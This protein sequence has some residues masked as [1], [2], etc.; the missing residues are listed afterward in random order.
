MSARHLLVFG[1]GYCGTEVARRAAVAGWTVT[2]THR[3]PAAPQATPPGIDVIPFDAADEILPAATHILATAA[4]TEAD[5]GQPGDPV[6]AR[7]AAAIAAAP[8]LAWVG[9]LSTTGVYGDRGG[10]WVDETTPVAPR[11]ARGCRRVEAEAAWRG[12]TGDRLDLFRL[13]G[14]YGPGRSPFAEL[15]AG[16]ARRVRKTGHMFGRIHRDDIA[17]AVLAAMAQDVARPRVLNLS[18]DAPAESADYI[19]EA[20]RLLGIDPPPE[21]DFAAAMGTMSPMALSFWAEDRKVA[22]EAT[23]RALGLRWRYPTYRDGLA[24]ILAAEAQ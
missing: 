13:A 18:D 8:R 1:L 22:C 23:Q 5:P 2:G 20:A 19:A 12:V 11:S 3:G 6:L 9:Y 16:R 24:A 7:H 15:R 21:L 17:A 10:A 4:P 14:I